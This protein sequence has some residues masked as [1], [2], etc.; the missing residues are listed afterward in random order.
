LPALLP[1]LAEARR[2]A[3]QRPWQSEQRTTARQLAGSWSLDRYG[4]RECP[5]ITLRRLIYQAS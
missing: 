4:H 3:P 2:R 5:Q 1:C